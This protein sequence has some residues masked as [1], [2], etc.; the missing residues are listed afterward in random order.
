MGET[1]KKTLREI[2]KGLE[3]EN[4]II[5]AARVGGQILGLDETVD[6]QDAPVWI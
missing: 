4:D 1:S 5:V 3:K 6:E 2:A